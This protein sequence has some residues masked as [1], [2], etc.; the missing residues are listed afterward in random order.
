MRFR[1]SVVRA[2]VACLT[3][4][5]GELPLAAEQDLPSPEGVVRAFVAA[6]N[7]RDIEAMLALAMDGI[8]W[9]SVDGAKVSIETAGKEALRASMTSYFASCSTCRSTLEWVSVGGSRVAALERAS[10]TAKDGSAKSQASLSVYE[11]AGGK[12]ARVYYFAAE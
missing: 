6:F 2:V 8:E 12:I 7:A 3:L 5:L 11:L 9:A 4:A 1:T 10:W